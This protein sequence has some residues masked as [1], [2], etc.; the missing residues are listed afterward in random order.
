MTTA[1]WLAGGLALAFAGAGIANFLGVGSVREDFRRWG[2]PAG[3]HRITGAIELVCAGLLLAP[4]TRIP[5]ALVLS[6]T[7]VAALGTLLRSRESAAHLVP[8][9]VLSAGLVGL[10]VLG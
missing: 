2:Y 6:V 5:A 9:F 7:M 10:F 1:D 8:A 3:F 4:V